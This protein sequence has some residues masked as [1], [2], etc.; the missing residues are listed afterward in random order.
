MAEGIPA[1]N[2]AAERF[3]RSSISSII[4]AG[5]AR[6]NIQ[7][8]KTRSNIPMDRQQLLPDVTK[9]LLN[10]IFSKWKRRKRLNEKVSLNVGCLLWEASMESIPMINRG[11]NEC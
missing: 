10:T 9:Q 11:K 3:A 5:L 8:L 2:V 7:P 6:K 4:W 1:C